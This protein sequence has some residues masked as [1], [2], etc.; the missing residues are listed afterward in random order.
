MWQTA[1]DRKEIMKLL[2][3]NV[4]TVSSSQ[5]HDHKEA[6]SGGRCP[7][8]GRSG[9]RSST[10]SPP[11]YAVL[12]PWVSGT[13]VAAAEQDGQATERPSGGMALL[14]ILLG[15]C[16]STGKSLREPGKRSAGVRY[17]YR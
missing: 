8:G 2:Y 16:L 11:S 13:H 10:Y 5:K 14:A 1:A 3:R 4:A 9:H 15:P 17:Q 6:P 7:P 12:Q